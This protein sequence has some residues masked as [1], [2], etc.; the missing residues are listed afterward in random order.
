MIPALK[1]TKLAHALSAGTIELSPKF[2]AI[3]EAI[4]DAPRTTTP[5]IVEL[6]VTSDGILMSRA[7]GDCGFNHIEG[8]FD[9]LLRNLSGVNGV[10]EATQGECLAW[11]NA[12][13]MLRI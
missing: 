7:V 11:K 9:D 1:D 8:G 2:T 3:L 10:L 12:A 6:V 5:A 4:L 13:R